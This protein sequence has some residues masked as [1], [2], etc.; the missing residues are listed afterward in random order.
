MALSSD[1]INYLMKLRTFKRSV[2]KLIPKELPKMNLNQFLTELKAYYDYNVY[3]GTTVEGQQM[4]AIFTH[5][6][7][8]KKDK[9]ILMPKLRLCPYETIALRDGTNSAMWKNGDIQTIL[10][11]YRDKMLINS[12]WK[13]S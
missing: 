2:G 5:Q 1:K 6:Y 10:T 4:N 11:I 3:Y 7:L 8:R 12:G 13:H 9:Q